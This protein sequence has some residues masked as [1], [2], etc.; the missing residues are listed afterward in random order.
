MK[1]ERPKLAVADD[2]IRTFHYDTRSWSSR[3]ESRGIYSTVETTPSASLRVTKRKNTKISDDLGTNSDLLP[4]DLIMEIFKRLPIKTLARLICVSKLWASIIRSPCFMTLFLAE[5][6]IRPGRLFFTFSTG[7]DCFFYSSLQTQ[8]PVGASVATY[9]TTHPVYDHTINSSSV[10]GLICYETACASGFVVYNSST[11][12]SITVPKFEPKSF[13]IKHFLGYDPIDGVYKIMCLSGP[14]MAEG[15]LVSHVLTLGNENPWRV[16]E[17]SHTHFPCS[18]QICINGVVYYEARAGAECK[19]AAVMSFDVRSETFGLIKRPVHAH[20]LL[21]C[22]TM[23]RYERKLAIMS[24]LI[25]AHGCIA[26]W[27][28]EDAAK[29]EWLKKVFVL[30]D[31]WTSLAQGKRTSSH[32][33]HRFVNVSDAG[34]LILAPTTFS[35]P[36][37]IYYVLY[38]DPERNSVRKVEIGLGGITEHNHKLLRCEKQG[39]CFVYHLF[40]SQGESLMFL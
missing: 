39:F 22:S 18:S 25:P 29:H 32:T 28:L 8:H 15:K 33:H 30:P 9:H 31:S 34:E 36:R 6:S 3:N 5:S 24:S 26:L 23:I 35:F 4:I 10:H 17:V 27:V 14:R 19:E 21:D 1:R 2:A 13:V 40:S 7:E 37:P 38:C 20:S 11:R 12:R 16:I